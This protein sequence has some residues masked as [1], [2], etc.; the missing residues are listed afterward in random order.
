VLLVR[1]G[2]SALKAEILKSETGATPVLRRRDAIVVTMAI[3]A[4]TG[5]RACRA[6]LSRQSSAKTEVQRKRVHEIE[7]RR[8][9][10]LNRLHHGLERAV[11]D[12]IADARWLAVE[13]IPV[14][15][16]TQDP[17]LF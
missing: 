7:I 9:V 2:K 3:R 13:L 4:S 17:F 11:A 5:T 15:V 6:D 8:P 10:G 16:N 1:P 14:C 12:L